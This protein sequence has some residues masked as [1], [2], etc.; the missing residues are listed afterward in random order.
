MNKQEAIR[1][2]AEGL[3]ESYVKMRAVEDLT[4]F[5]LFEYLD[6]L[7]K[8]DSVLIEL[9]E[10]PPWECDREIVDDYL[11]GRIEYEEMLTKVEEAKARFNPDDY[12]E[13]VVDYNKAYGR[14]PLG[15]ESR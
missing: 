6:S 10:V 4:G 2:I 12:E 7:T 5:S 11:Y 9:L 3:R 8:I 13:F 15:G 14:H 1:R